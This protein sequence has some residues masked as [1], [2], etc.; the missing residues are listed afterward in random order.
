[1]KDF[2]AALQVG[3]IMFATAMCGAGWGSDGK[4]RSGLFD[5]R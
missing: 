4:M 2:L 3:F 1:M 5:R